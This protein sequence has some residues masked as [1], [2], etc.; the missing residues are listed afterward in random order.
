MADEEKKE[1]KDGSEESGSQESEKSE[2]KNASQNGGN[3]DDGSGGD[4]Q[5]DSS[6][7]SSADNKDDESG[8]DSGSQK[9]QQD[10]GGEG[11]GETI[12]YI[13]WIAAGLGALLVFG[14]LSFMTYKAITA[15]G[16]PPDL[17]VRVKS[18]EQMQTGYLVKFEVKNN[19][20]YS[21]AAA[22]I[23][24]ELKQGDKTEETSTTT[25]DYVPSYSTRSGGIFFSKNPRDYQLDL[26]ATG[27]TEP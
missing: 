27:Y 24:G 11:N 14:S 12:T 4:K 16:K 2:K 10:D 21:A 6:S 13:E 3:S 25:V 5:N 15:I 20:E 9:D 8:K 26:R 23:K 1:E 17:T 19:G 22:N 7:S 18:I